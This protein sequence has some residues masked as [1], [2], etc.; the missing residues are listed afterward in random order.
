VL[1][2]DSTELGKGENVSGGPDGGCACAGCHGVLE[3]WDPQRALPGKEKERKGAAVESLSFGL[4]L[5]VF[6][7]ESQGLEFRV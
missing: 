6:R 1:G 3:T 5:F 4:L 2:D 7:R